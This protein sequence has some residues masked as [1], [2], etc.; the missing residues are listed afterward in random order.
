MLQAPVQ[1]P[2][3]L[4]SK[5]FIEKAKPKIKEEIKKPSIFC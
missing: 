5:S 3:P 2:P 4:K 1:E